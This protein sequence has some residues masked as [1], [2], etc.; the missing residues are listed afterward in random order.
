MKICLFPT[1]PFSEWNCHHMA[2][3]LGLKGFTEMNTAHLDSA[4]DKYQQTASQDRHVFCHHWAVQLS[5]YSASS[6]GW[7]ETSRKKKKIVLTTH[8][9]LWTIII[10]IIRK[11]RDDIR[12][13]RIFFV[14]L[15][16]K[17]G[18]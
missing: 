4:A 9:L 6:R 2:S 3:W 13:A 8:H 12:D 1:T 15:L 11:I 7:E 17:M 5:Q 16:I 14:F 10:I 18:W